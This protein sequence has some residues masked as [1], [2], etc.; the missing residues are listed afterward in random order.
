MRLSRPHK[1]DSADKSIRWVQANDLL[2]TAA[3]NIRANVA[4]NGF[5][6]INNSENAASQQQGQL[7]IPECKTGKIRVSQG[8]CWWVRSSC[9]R[10]PH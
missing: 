3:D 9:L 1:R 6:D 8:D 2:P 5:A 10:E 7:P 4:W